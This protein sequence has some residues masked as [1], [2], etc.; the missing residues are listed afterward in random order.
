MLVV[1]RKILELLEELVD[2]FGNPGLFPVPAYVHVAGVVGGP[3]VVSGPAAPFDGE[4]WVYIF[5]V[6]ADVSGVAFDFFGGFLFGFDAFAV[7]V[8]FG[9]SLEDS[10]EGAILCAVV[11]A[12]AIVFAVN[13]HPCDGL[14][15]HI[16][17]FGEP[18][19]VIG[20]SVGGGGADAVLHVLHERVAEHGSIAESRD[21]H[22]ARVDAE[23]VI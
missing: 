18:N 3:L 16:V 17:P 15:L 21:E 19:V 1:Y 2:F 23:V 22:A 6:V 4:A 11:I 12:A 7:L 14:L 10:R 20:D 5:E 9:V 8:D 13:V